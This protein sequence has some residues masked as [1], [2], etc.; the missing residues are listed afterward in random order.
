MPIEEFHQLLTS[1]MSAKR[2]VHPSLMSPDVLV[3]RRQISAGS[4][5]EKALQ[6]KL[7]LQT[8]PP[9]SLHIS[10]QVIQKRNVPIPMYLKISMEG[11][12]LTR[13]H[14]LL[15]LIVNR[16][17]IL[18]MVHVGDRSITC[19]TN[20]LLLPSLLRKLFLDW[21]LKIRVEAL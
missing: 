14:T 9:H 13:N 17:G 20:L 18:I 16:A 7:S 12:K 3:F 11:T 5:K 10:I 21:S 4:M 15:C 19:T 8:V 6:R 2:P 1:G